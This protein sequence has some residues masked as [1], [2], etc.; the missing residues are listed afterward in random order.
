MIDVNAGAAGLLARNR[1]AGRRSAD[2]GEAFVSADFE[3]IRLVF[4]EATIGK[5]DRRQRNQLVGCMHAHNEL[6]VLNRLLLFAMNAP[7]EGEPHE[8]S[9]SV[10][11][12][13]ILQV[14]AGKLFQTWDMLEDRFLRAN[15]EDPAL[16]ALRADIRAS[17]TWLRQ[18]FRDKDNAL[19][20]VRDKTAFHYDRQG[21]DLTPAIDHLAEGE[22]TVYL[23]L[24]PANTIY[25]L[26]SALLYR[27]AFAEVARRRSPGIERS[28]V[29]LVGEGFRTIVE[30]AK[31]ANWHLH[32]LLHG[33]V[34]HLLEV[35]AGKPLRK[36]EQKRLPISGAPDPDSVSLPLFIDIGAASA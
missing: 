27:T 35:A 34:N 23:A 29:E 19:R 33:L 9:W 5:L 16:A 18:Y 1:K 31:L 6:T 30:D 17:L 12:W 10:Q 22:D 25:F 8:S 11:G 26:G 7:D 20:F 15:T 13:T 28:H 32:L 21:L 2:T 4:D 3:V 36:L 24:H 14:L